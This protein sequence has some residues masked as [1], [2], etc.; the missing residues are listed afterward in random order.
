[1]E[2]EKRCFNHST[3]GLAILCFF[4]M[5]SCGSSTKTIAHSM[6]SQVGT[7][8]YDQAVSRW[9]PPI[10]VLGGSGVYVAVWLVEAPPNLGLR[11]FS[12]LMPV[13]AESLPQGYPIV[14]SMRHGEALRIAFDEGTR[15]M[16]DWSYHRW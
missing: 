3:L 16:V 2:K 15:F 13:L 9:G 7:L 14:S 10:R 8:T 12:F 11:I 5:V 4:L 1:M 6:D